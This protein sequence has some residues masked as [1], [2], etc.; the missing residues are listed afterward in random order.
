M[1]ILSLLICTFVGVVA[2][3][4]I[5]VGLYY[6]P[7]LF[8]EWN[9]ASSRMG[10]YLRLCCY[11]LGCG[12]PLIKGV[13][14]FFQDPLTHTPSLAAGLTI[15]ILPSLLLAL[16]WGLLWGRDFRAV[17]IIAI[18]LLISVPPIGI[19]GWGNP[20]TAAGMFFPG[21]GWMGLILTLLLCILVMHQARY[22]VTTLIILSVVASSIY[23]PKNPPV[24]WIAI[25]TNLGWLRDDMDDYAHHEVLITLADSHITPDTRLILFPEM[26]VGRWTENS[27][28]LWRNIIKKARA[29]NTTILLGTTIQEP[30]GD[31]SNVMLTLATAT[32]LPDRVPVPI[33]MWTPWK[34][35][36]A[37]SYF[38]SNGIHPIAGKKIATLICYEQLLVWPVL[39][40][41]MYHPDILMT[42]ANDWWA[43]D[44]VIP[45][46]QQEAVD[47][48]GRLFGV[49]VLSSK[50][51]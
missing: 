43:K 28:F 22:V 14:V 39:H 29:N 50:N 49:A 35:G 19:V 7:L 12:Y 30:T 2:W 13:A 15:W 10:A 25:N 24:G 51:Q 9:R 27:A 16:P 20:L 4:G 17:R 31:Y 6:I 40:S 33:S 38:S 34:R 48:W 26:V 41:M 18:I 42:A 47:A 44:T 5:I 1:F 36:G 23:Q 8:L 32:V 21:W 45:G 37:T 46:I 11:Y 3:H